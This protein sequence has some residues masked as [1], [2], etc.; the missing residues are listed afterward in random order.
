VG[1]VF[2]SYRRRGAPQLVGALH[3]LMVGHLGAPSVFLDVESIEHGDR[4]PDHLRARLNDADVVLVVMHPG[5]ATETDTDGTRLLFRDDDWVRREVHQALEEG[6]AVVPV[7]L[8]DPAERG[9]AD[10]PPGPDLLPPDIAGLA[11]QHAAVLYPRTFHADAERLLDRCARLVR[12]WE[13]PP[14]EPGTP[15]PDRRRQAAV[16]AV[17]A[18]VTPLL[19]TPFWPMTDGFPWGLLLIL[20]SLATVFLQLTTAVVL[21]PLQRPIRSYERLF[22][23]LPFRS[24]W[25]IPLL[26]AMTPV[27]GLVVVALVQPG[28]TS[29]G[30]VV[31]LTVGVATLLIMLMRGS[32][33]VYQEDQRDREW[34]PQ[35]GPRPF[36]ASVRRTSAVLI[37]RVQSWPA[38][39]SS[40]QHAQAGWL[41]RQIQLRAAEMVDVTAHGR[42]VWY[43]G[44]GMI[45][46]HATCIG[47]TLG[48]AAAILIQRPHASIAILFGLLGAVVLACVAAA[49]LGYR[50]TDASN[51]ALADELAAGS[52]PRVERLLRPSGHARTPGDAQGS[53]EEV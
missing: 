12:G 6:K 33:S 5:W 41:L 18:T 47:L 52:L 40:D 34:P 38:P 28:V 19:A 4:Y 51:R 13:V 36:P 31:T 30:A 9:F 43:S 29:G 14:D 42:R 8:G 24:Y 49:E 27:I 37:D 48:G 17:V 11:F 26:L 23:A 53:G 22:H 2:I 3:A 46:L 10:L 7:V 50:V 32:Y 21:R 44:T 45:D 15:R 20:G 16:V 39:L 1:G 35:R 25:L